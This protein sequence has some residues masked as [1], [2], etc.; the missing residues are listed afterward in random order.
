MSIH[1]LTESV[2]V[3]SGSSSTIWN[4]CTL[5]IPKG[6]VIITSDN[7]Y[8]KR[9]NGKDRYIDLDTIFNIEDINTNIVASKKYHE[10]S[11]ENDIIVINGI[12][13]ITSD[14]NLTNTINSLNSIINANSV[15]DDK[16]T[17]IDQKLNLV[18]TNITISDD[19]KI[20]T[21]VNGKIAP[22]ITIDALKD[23]AGLTTASYP[24]YIESFEI[25]NDIDCTIVTTEMESSTTYYT[26]FEVFHDTINNDDLE[27]SLTIDNE[28]FKI[29]RVDYELFVIRTPE[30]DI[31]TNID[32]TLSVSYNDNIVTKV[33][34]LLINRSDNDYLVGAI[35]GYDYNTSEVKSY[36]NDIEINNDGSIIIVGYTIVNDITCGFVM[37]TDQYFNIINTSTVN[38][39][40]E[41]SYHKVILRDD[42]IY[43][44][45]Y[46]YDTNAIYHVL[47][48]D[49]DLNIIAQKKHTNSSIYDINIGNDYLLLCGYITIDNVP[50]L[51]IFKYD[52]DLN[53][54]IS[55]SYS[56]GYD[57]YIKGVVIHNDYI[58]IATY[59]KTSLLYRNVGII[60]LDTNLNIIADK[61]YGSDDVQYSLTPY[62]IQEDNDN[63]I[64]YGTCSN[65]TL[66]NSAFI[67]T[68]DTDLELVD[69][70]LINCVDDSD[71]SYV[72]Y[73]LRYMLKHDSYYYMLPFLN[74][75]S[76][77]THIFKYDSNFNL[78]KKVLFD[79][80]SSTLL[81]SSVFNTGDYDN[82]FMYLIGYAYD[83][84]VL[85]IPYGMFDGD[86]A[87]SVGAL[88]NIGL[89]TEFAIDRVSYNTT[90][91]TNLT[92]FQSLDF[93]SVYIDYN[94][95]IE[96]SII[97]HTSYDITVDREKI[98]LT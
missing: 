51:V 91:T 75:N 61:I 74:A 21:I 96:N 30:F 15:Q 47:K 35:Y 4:E 87:F 57:D 31:D 69:N 92:A 34:T 45:G 70:K 58:Y 3:L 46:V 1:D 6:V 17:S 11:G 41:S 54:M 38:S 13:Y 89:T 14:V 67:L 22:G 53:I 40:E 32:I 27:I 24:M 20:A 60:K 86:Y 90:I 2:V 98:I 39:I 12:T 76:E 66:S 81:T 10:L 9:G 7:K 28:F 84:F 44:A 85:K 95:T 59:C 5:P 25:Y 62:G 63:L 50:R 94:D 64:I 55:K 93:T 26:K 79:V 77:Y 71:D 36:Y 82:K 68:L 43:V 56:T 19:D 33:K 52:L 78:I 8:V 72:S 88:E 83:C 23:L 80:P 49:S 65:T 48:L 97:S 16:I 37:K 73:S 29:E 42:Y 18:D